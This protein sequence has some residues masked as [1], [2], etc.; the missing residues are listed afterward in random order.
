MLR[1]LSELHNAGHH[2]GLN[3]YISASF[4]ETTCRLWCLYH[5]LQMVSI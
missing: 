5:H 3:I 1:M 4:V 2:M